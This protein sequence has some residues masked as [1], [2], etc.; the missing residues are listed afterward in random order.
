MRASVK[1]PLSTEEHVKSKKQKVAPTED[2]DVEN[3]DGAQYGFLSCLVSMLMLIIRVTLCFDGLCWIIK[4]LARS[5]RRLLRI[6]REYEIKKA[7]FTY[8]REM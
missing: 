6:L 4:Y 1:R 5:Y 3:S 8:K 7:V 2:M